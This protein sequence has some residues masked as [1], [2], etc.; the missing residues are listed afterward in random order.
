MVRAL[1]PALTPVIQ[2][3]PGDKRKMPLVIG[4]ENSPHRQGA[5]GDQYVKR[6]TFAA[7]LLG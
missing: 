1:S 5:S 4:Y 7:S 6:G 3:K 2:L